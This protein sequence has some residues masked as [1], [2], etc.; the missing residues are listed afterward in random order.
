MNPQSRFWL[1]HKSL[2]IF[3]CSLLGMLLFYIIHR[4]VALIWVSLIQYDPIYNLGFDGLQQL[5]FYLMTSVAAILIGGWYGVWLGLYWHELV[6]ERR[7]DEMERKRVRP[8]L[9]SVV[10]SFKGFKQINVAEQQAK[11]SAKVKEHVRQ[12]MDIRR[13][14]SGSGR[15]VAAASMPAPA[16]TMPVVVSPTRVKI[17]EPKPKPK[18]QKAVRKIAKKVP[19]KAL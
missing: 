5:G 1:A 3:L 19:A 8:F 2:Y 11:S 16:M 9:P 4:A 10:P 14:T 13:P 17:E 18:K 6:Y 15:V 12:P 7:H